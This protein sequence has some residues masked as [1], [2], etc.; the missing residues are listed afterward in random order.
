MCNKRLLLLNPL[1]TFQSKYTVRVFEMKFIKG[2]F[3][4]VNNFIYPSFFHLLYSMSVFSV[5]SFTIF[6]VVF[7]LVN[8]IHY[9]LLITAYL[10]MQELSVT[11]TSRLSSDEVKL[12]ENESDASAVSTRMFLNQQ[13]WD[14]FDYVKSSEKIINDTFKKCTRSG[15]S[16][17]KY[18]IK[19]FFFL[20]IIGNIFFR[21]QCFIVYCKETWLLYKQVF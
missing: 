11:I 4:E 6:L 8:I 10:D 1:R 17:L 12:V 9:L 19:K 21:F 16:I 15:N 13:E 14:L 18:V 7:I 5:W 20:K 2:V 3:H